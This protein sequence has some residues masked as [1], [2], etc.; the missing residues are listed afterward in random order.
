MQLFEVLMLVAKH[1]GDTMLPRIGMM[2]AL[3]SHDKSVP[4][5]RREEGEEVSDR[6]IDCRSSRT[7]HFER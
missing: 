6:P 1:G 7:Q 4:T 3:Y 5:A 2:R